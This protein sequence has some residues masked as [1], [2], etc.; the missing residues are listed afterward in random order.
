MPLWNVGV[1]PITTWSPLGNLTNWATSIWRAHTHTQ[2]KMVI[3]SLGHLVRECNS[4]EWWDNRGYE[5]VCRFHLKH[6]ICSLA[7]CSIPQHYERDPGREGQCNQKCSLGANGRK[8]AFIV[9]GLCFFFP[10]SNRQSDKIDNQI[11]DRQTHR[12]TIG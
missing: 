11:V 2:T 4:R 12:Q 5:F 7:F 10:I 3:C 1:K 9:Y 6:H 8:N